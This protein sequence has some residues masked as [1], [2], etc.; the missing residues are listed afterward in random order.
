M[1]LKYTFLSIREQ[2][3]CICTGAVNHQHGCS[4]LF[5][6]FLLRRLTDQ[7]HILFT[8]FAIVLDFQA[9]VGYF[10][11]RQIHFTNDQSFIYD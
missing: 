7:R 6:L 8:G 5:A 11:F 3:I 10:T 1:R 9:L 4:P 2:V